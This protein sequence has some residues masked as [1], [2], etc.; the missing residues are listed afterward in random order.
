MSRSSGRAESMLRVIPVRKYKYSL[1]LV[2]LQE[3]Q[4]CQWCSWS[5]DYETNLSLLVEFRADVWTSG[6]TV[7][8]AAQSDRF[9]T[10][11]YGVSTIST[12]F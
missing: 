8:L 3:A 2:Q 10:N 4:C 7:V 12:A 9:V 6:N 1:L 11:N 5:R